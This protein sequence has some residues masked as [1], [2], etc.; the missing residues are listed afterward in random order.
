MVATI[1]RFIETLDVKSNKMNAG[2]SHHNEKSITCLNNLSKLINLHISSAF[3]CVEIS[4][5]RRGNMLKTEMMNRMSE[6]PE[7]ASI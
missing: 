3:S 6:N 1:S 4:T 5:K 7:F 2:H